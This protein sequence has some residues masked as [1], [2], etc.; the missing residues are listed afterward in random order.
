MTPSERLYKRLVPAYL[1]PV[2]IWPGA[3]D[4]ILAIFDAFAAEAV[5]AEREAC[6][7]EAEMDSVLDWGGGST[8]NAKGTAR[9]IVAAIRARTARGAALREM[10]DEVPK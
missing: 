7:R 10:A 3:K 2:Q 5:R 9:R 1:V 8:G 4:Q 6:A